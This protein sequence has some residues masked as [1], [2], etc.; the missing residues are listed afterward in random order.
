MP[1]ISTKLTSELTYPWAW[2]AVIAHSITCRCT[3][4][5]GA[6]SFGPEDI[7]TIKATERPLKGAT[8]A[9]VQ[10]PSTIIGRY[11][12]DNNRQMRM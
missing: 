3:L 9:H 2:L 11:A 12:Y 5:T 6:V 1:K 4:L 8:A 10:P 7:H